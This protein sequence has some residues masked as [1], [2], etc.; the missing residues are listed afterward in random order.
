MQNCMKNCKE[1]HAICEQTIVYCLQ[2][3][4]QHAE[5]H[6]IQTLLD[7]A[8]IC[9]TSEDFLLRNSP[10]HP[11]TC[12]VCAQACLRCAESC[13]KMGNDPQAK[14]IISPSRRLFCV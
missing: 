14:K 7:C 11:Q 9:Q 1:C 6:H 4:G 13:E 3:G 2:Q 8:Q 10:L 12:Q 5:A